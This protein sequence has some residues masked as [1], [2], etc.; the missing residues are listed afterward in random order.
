M[1]VVA[2]VEIVRPARA[3]VDHRD[4][5]AVSGMIENHV[6]EV[7]YRFERRA[8]FTDPRFCEGDHG[9]PHP[10]APVEDALAS[11]PGASRPRWSVGLSAQ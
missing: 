3:M 11:P 1:S 2:P 9:I 6:A 4:R 5:G 8:L 10:E 7:R